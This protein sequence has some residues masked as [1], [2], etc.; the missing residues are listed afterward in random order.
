MKPT[1]SVSAT[2]APNCREGYP[3]PLMPRTIVFVITVVLAIVFVV[4][5]A[6]VGTRFHFRKAATAGVALRDARCT[7]RAA[8]GARTA[9]KV[10]TT[11]ALALA[12]AAATVPTSSLALFVTALLVVCI[13]LSI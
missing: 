12:L 13:V 9:A 4:A 10:A 5:V 2:P 7:G 11:P 6:T 3:R 1:A 8:A